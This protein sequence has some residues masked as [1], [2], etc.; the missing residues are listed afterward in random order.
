M[1]LKIIID[2]LY[3][4]RHV[5]FYTEYAPSIRAER[6]GLKVM[7]CK[8]FGRLTGAKYDKMYEQSKRIYIAP[9]VYHPQFILCKEE[10]RK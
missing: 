10:I 3:K 9:M 7:M 4:N 1:K 6:N 8:E 5:R 2:D